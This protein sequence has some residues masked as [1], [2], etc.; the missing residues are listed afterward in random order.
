MS[1]VRQYLCLLSVLAL[2]SSA[3][4][5][6]PVFYLTDGD[7]SIAYRIDLGTGTYLGSFATFSLGYP[8]AIGDTV[9]I[10][11]RDNGTGYEYNLN[12]TP[13]GVTFAGSSYISE[14]LDG[15]TD[16][17]MYNFAVQCCAGP[18]YVVRTDRMWQN[19]SLLFALPDSGRGIAF[20]P[21]D[22]TLWVS[23]YDNTVRQ[24][25]QA[26]V[27]IS[28]FAYSGSWRAL[29]YDASSDSLWAFV[30]GGNQFVQFD[31]SGNILQN[32]TVEGLYASNPFGG[33]IANASSAVPEPGSLILFGL[34]ALAF[35]RKRG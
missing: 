17:D 11:Q 14:L 26:G 5:A 10:A 1:H 12:G 25:T 20:D 7:S 21:V 31:R 13:T 3:A 2:V 27:Q 15:T 28:Q 32:L 35:L 8:V 24:Y 18:N 4:W 19:S 29:A 30:G 16:G 33:E 9:R 23:L 22:G 34:G 6:G